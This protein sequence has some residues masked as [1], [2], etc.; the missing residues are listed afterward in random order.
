MESITKK[1]NPKVL[2]LRFLYGLSKSL[3]LILGIFALSGIFLSQNAQAQNCNSQ[4]ITVNNFFFTD[5][6]GNPFPPGF[7]PPNYDPQNPP[8]I[9]GKIF[10]TFGGS[11]SNGYSA[12]LEYDIIIDDVFLRKEVVCLFDRQKIIQGSPQQ[13]STFSWVYG[14]KIELKNF[15]MSWKTNDNTSCEKLDR[16]A[17][18]WSSPAGFLVRTPLVSR[19]DFETNCDD[20]T[21]DFENLT[22][23]G[24]PSDYTFKW[25]FSNG[26][27]NI[28]T[29]VNPQN[30][31]FPGPGTYSV[32]LEATSQQI[33]K[34]VTRDVILYPN[35]QLSFIKVDDDCTPNSTGSIDIS[36]QGGLGQYTYA[37][38][39]Q[40]GS[41]L[42]ASDED[43]TG[44]SEGV[45]NV[46]VT[47]E[48]GC[49]VIEQIQIIKPSESP[50]P[51]PANFEF[52]EG[53]GDQLLSVT[54][55]EGYEILWYDE[56]QNLLQ[57]APTVDTD[58]A[59]QSTFFISQLK[60]GE[61]E[62]MKAQ[63]NV[64]VNPAPSAPEADDEEICET[65]PFTNLTATAT[66][67]EGFS[68]IW[69]TSE[70]GEGTTQ[71]PS[72]TEVGTVTYYAAAIND[73][74]GCESLE[75]TPVTLTINAAPAAPVS[76]GDQEICETE[77][78]T[79]LTATATVGEGF[80]VIWY[81]SADGEGTTQTPSLTEVGTVTYYAAAVND[82]T[83]CE[84]LERTPVTLTIN[85]AP[86]A[87]VSGGD[88]EIC[89]TEPFTSLT[90]TATVGEGFS[91]IWYTSAD[92]EGTT[93]TP[94]LTEVGT[95]TY[96]AAAVND[97][98]GCESLTR[99]PVTLTINAAPAAPVSGGD[100]EICETEPFTSLTATATVGEGFS[101][102]WYTSADGEGTTQTPSLTEVGT[103]TY[104]AAAVNDETGCES[105]TRT[106]VT[107]TINAAPAAPVS[108]GNQVE[109]LKDPIQTLTATAT[110]GEGFTLVWYTS[111]DGTE[112]TESPTLNE[113][114]TVTY[115]AAAINNETGCESLTRTAVLLSILDSPEPPISGGD[116][117]I[118]EGDAEKITATAS[119]PGTIVWYDQPEGGN[120]I[121]DPSLSEVGT[122]TYYAQSEGESCSSLERTP[123]TL[124]INAA[125]A[126]PVSG[127]DQEI[128]ET[129]PFTSLT[130]TA[131]VGEGF[132][133][134]WY[135]SADGE[136]TTQTPSLT[137]VGTVTYYAA[138]INDETGC[139][140]L[141]RTPVTLTINAAPAAPVSGGD[142]EIC[143]TE[144][145]T[146]LTATATVGEGFSVIWYTS[147][148]G[149]G[150]TQ[151]PS[152]TEV[153]TVTYYAAAVND[154]TG[155]ESLTRTPVTLTIN[156][157]PAAPVSG[158]DQEI[159]ETDPFTSLTATATVGEGFSV[160]WYTS[161]DGEGTTQTP[162]LTEV[163]TVTYYAAAFNNETGCE[164]LT[165]TPVTLTIN[166]APAAPVSGGD[167]EICETE[168][169]TSL[170]A[171]A[172]VGEGFSV[173]WYT[174]AD[175][176]GTTQ[177]PSLTE[178]G[179]VTYYAAA[180]N[181][182][183][184][185]E[186]LTRTPVTLTINAAPAAPVSGG[187]QEICET[188]PFTSLTA[189][190]TVGEGFSVIWY[191]SED[192]EGTTQTPSL[193]EVGTVTYYAAAVN[194]ETGC[195]SLTR[196]PVTLTI[197]AAPA[198]PVSGGNQVECL[199]DPIQTLTATATVGEGFTLV[200]YTSADGTEIT[201]SPTLNEVG[202]VTYYAAAI[203]NETG[204][205][206]LTRT[207]VLLSILDSPEPPISGGD[208]TICEGDAEKITATASGPGTIVWY[209]Q[210]EGGNVIEDPSL[211]E[212]G[213]VT[214]YAQSEGESCSSLERT[215]VTLT[216]N[217]A[218]AA[219]VSGGDQEICET[220]PFTSL[221][222][223]A[224]V[225]E[226]FSVIWYTSA[227]GEGT[228]QTPSLTEVGTV[229]YYAAAVN[230]ETGCESLERTPVTLTINAAPAA[231]VSGGDQEICETEPFTSLTATA[232][233]GEGFSVIWYT[234]ADGE[235]T[236]QTPSLTE[237]GTVTYYAAAVNDETGCES[238]TRTPVTLTINAAPAAPVSGGDQ[239]ICETEPFTSLTA[240]ATVGEGFSVIWYTSADGE[241]TTQT[242]SLTE[243]GTVTYYAAAIN[244]E[245]GCESLERTPVTLTINAAPAAPV[246]G[247]DQ[248][249][250]ETEPFTSLTATATV[251]EG[252][253][254]IWYTSADGEGTTQTPS[255]T[256]VG[257][258]TYYAAA[259]NN[260]TGCESLTR[261]P[262]TLT[263]N[264]APAAPV[265]GGDQ[266]I[267]ETDPFTSLTATATVGE[268][269]SVI[270]Y[271]SE[272][273]EGTTQTPSLTEVGTVT[274]YAA[275]FNNETGCE[276]L[277]RTPVT[278]TINAAPVAPVSGGNQETCFIQEGQ[279][280]TASASVPQ[281]FSIIWYNSPEGGQVVEPTLSEV[282]TVTYYAASINNTTGC[283]SIERTAVTLTL[284]TCLISIEKTADVDS[285]TVAGQVVTYTLTIRNLSTIT[286]TDV[287]VLDPLTGLNQVIP[288]IEVGGVVIIETQYTVTQE[289]I[290]S[291]E[292]ENIAS[293]TGNAGEEEVSDDATLII[294]AVQNPDIQIEIT[295][296]DAVITEAGQE[297]P[298]TITVTNTGN[299]TL[300][301]VT[302][303][304]TKTGLVVNIGTLKPGET[305]TVETT[306][307]VTQED[308]DDGEVTNEA[309][310]TG[311]SPNA[312][313]D[314]PTDSD[315]VTTPITPAPGI[316]IVKSSDKSEI[317][318]LGET[319]TY[320]LVVTNTGNVTLTNIL[321][322]DP[323]TGLNEVI[324][325]LAPGESVTIE[326]SY[327]VTQEDLD[328]GS[329][330]NVAT[331]SGE[332]PDGE[333][334][335]DEDEVSIGVGIREIIANDDDFGTYFV[336]YGGR[337][338]NI[339]E[340][341]LLD[342]QRPD[343]ADVDFEFTELDGV[344]G[345]LIDENGDLSLIPGVNEAREYT[346][347]YVLR[348]VANPN[349]SDDAF[350]VFRLLNDN[351][352]LGVS[353]EALSD[354]VFEGDEF[355]YEIVVV[356]QGGT[357]ARN[358]VIT[359]NLPN[360]VTYLSNRVESNSANVEVNVNVSGS[361]ITWRIP[362][363]PA[364]A[365]IVF[366]VR[367]KA[368]AAGTVTN[369][370]IVGADEDDTDES[371][372]QD[373]D[374]TEIRPFH[375]PNVITPN[376]DG[377]N[378]TFEIQ[379]LNKFVS[380]E[381]T[382]INRFGDHVL[383]QS[384]YRN[385]WNAPGQ[386]AGTYF[387][388]LVTVDSQGRE[389]VFKGWIHV[390]KND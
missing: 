344:I 48:R 262:V 45:Y 308:V 40:D 105:L 35:L 39:T 41:G 206:S 231:P 195:E 388:I 228:T 201:E 248:E 132:S 332:T 230:D 10:A 255:L 288:S 378:D 276:S 377:L 56:N 163:G 315:S 54:P 194:D 85:A 140:S 176:E 141:E 212:V 307:P 167:Q 263:I 154:E 357:D 359:D 34:S 183:T 271:T 126:A 334:I 316:S 219:P 11:S 44:L 159:C 267:C 128:C 387:Y 236:T 168:P 145:F 341:D 347:R 184:G 244:D 9:Q 17:Q 96:Y 258:V 181:D 121:E 82:E 371:D 23:G 112:I 104:Y 32:K 220:D 265:S 275:A 257:T 19:F 3:I 245:T 385:D 60:E 202:T 382:I 172:T 170:T 368:G 259:F 225:G 287:N 75:R 296:N 216:I 69:Y 197:N 88:Q 64:I 98:T 59:G 376:N 362:F 146:N 314:D 158:G 237:V 320:T 389:H 384:N 113:V 43:Q 134:I 380:N 124:T 242:P 161:E 26:T 175:G 205:E 279:T 199:K 327:V 102:I 185:C 129:E 193:T 122:V 282:G 253:S 203:N 148:D 16:N 179:T 217:A 101:V 127:G 36:V 5:E 93:Q 25:T 103:V 38:T 329:L 224:T 57:S 298:Y 108:G 364:D 29:D 70:D 309:S 171:T 164:S 106:P 354:E 97:E 107:L 343:P 188:D 260:E 116:I 166:A 114:G 291:G 138:A 67:E 1:I 286:L 115:Y 14:S 330:L 272:D 58:I 261:T 65:S 352:N 374:V 46:T 211:S 55:A 74:T 71:T 144:P 119:G 90:A 292:L 20:F 2:S 269:F 84:S 208:I 342:G 30:I 301:N 324:E 177:T 305:K 381:I 361:A 303:V 233:V 373:S 232:T 319:V 150:T 306:Y 234:S 250:C 165:R 31:S 21:V 221:T 155:C 77:P 367:V 72:L 326:T 78:F 273:G 370:V 73:E 356:N 339:L 8:T 157:A 235:G 204:C 239:E 337:L 22:T 365:R 109:C 37:W 27:P 76:G 297:I 375:I 118:C 13:I 61:C 151:T 135:T 53:S 131:T 338:G 318:D 372:N 123:V 383:E 325:T 277:T 52:C 340:N 345:L 350:V 312:G 100:Q 210:P 94:S 284:N 50:A 136:G 268:G 111:A 80:S 310:V 169:F 160:I 218:P 51:S 223:T 226:G 328:R 302:V 130:A 264:A 142:Q 214:Y 198:A 222:A 254:V 360:G 353:K 153:G 293:V 162:S 331:V 227:D 83:G 294:P 369:T 110:V 349:N 299:V 249:I 7:E 246:S 139:E 317:R 379:G 323:L 200:W 358:V 6:N 182:E 68:V 178:L 386:K 252:F 187:D 143:E 281:G 4:N 99:T 304:D 295:D 363:F 238:L 87:P 241:G 18:C 196:T 207:A 300:T 240:T 190:A 335:G 346:L 149:E 91:V 192:G 290:D 28:S 92:G 209:D 229:T 366:R 266:E 285:V 390:I 278:L 42:V 355:E 180:V 348:E 274:Y 81:T 336:S 49:S 322:S 137:E 215:P 66:V 351:V 33:T 186:S 95:V 333:Q 133:V 174:S 189:T 152:L 289:D 311:E 63:I 117:T 79:N 213:T 173:I 147:A 47:D 251:G 156:A 313:D 247:G 62:S 321:V 89:E 283:E 120:V 270:W 191:T 24:N 12:Y 125:P 256:E 243:V 86:A 15:F 280:L